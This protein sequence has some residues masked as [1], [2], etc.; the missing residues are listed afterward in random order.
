MQTSS[1]PAAALAQPSSTARRPARPSGTLKRRRVAAAGSPPHAPNSQQMLLIDASEPGEP[2]TYLIDLA[3][4]P[5]PGSLARLMRKWLG[6]S[7]CYVRLGAIAEVGEILD[8]LD[9]DGQEDGEEGEEDEDGEEIRSWFGQ[10]M[11]EANQYATAF[12]ADRPL[13]AFVLSLTEGWW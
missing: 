13:P 11:V 7:A 9:G 1:P 5:P 6:T 12:Q 4:A 3:R 10:Q 2:V 8:E